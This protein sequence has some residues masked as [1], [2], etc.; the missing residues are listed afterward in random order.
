MTTLVRRAYALLAASSAGEAAQD[1]YLW[2]SMPS[3]LI[4]LSAASGFATESTT[5]GRHFYTTFFLPQ[6]A[7]AMDLRHV[8][9]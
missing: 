3:F 5:I 4:G 6:H 1:T 7:L 9:M 2:N 8:M